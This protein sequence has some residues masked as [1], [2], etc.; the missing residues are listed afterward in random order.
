MTSNV[1]VPKTKI[2]NQQPQL[3]ATQKDTGRTDLAPNHSQSPLPN[4]QD[5]RDKL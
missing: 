4:Q 3:Q 5:S 2:V 1:A